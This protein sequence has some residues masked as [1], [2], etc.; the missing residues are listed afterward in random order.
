LN[1]PDYKPPAPGGIFADVPIDA[2]YAKWV[3]P[4]YELG[5]IEACQVEPELRYCPM[6]PLTRAVAAYMMVQAK[7]I[8]VP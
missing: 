5:L 1:G 7:G 8:S 3:E 4:A 6:E 2:W